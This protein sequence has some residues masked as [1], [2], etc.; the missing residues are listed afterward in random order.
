VNWVVYLFQFITTVVISRLLSPQQVGIFTLSMTIVLLLQ[1]LREFGVVSYIVQEKDLSDAKI[2]TVFATTI[3]V[4]WL[5]AS[6]LFASRSYVSHFYGEPTLEAILIIL[7]IS[8]V[9][10]PFGLPATAMLRRERQF[11]KLGIIS[12]SSSLVNLVTACSLA[13]YGFEARSLAY[14]TLASG[15]VQVAVSLFFWPKH[16][17]LKPSFSEWRDVLGFGLYASLASLIARIGQSSP[18]LLIGKIFG[19][20]DVAIFSRGRVLPLLLNRLVTSPV[21]NAVVPE[22]ANNLRIGKSTSSTL[23]DIISN[24]AFIYWSLLAFLFV[25]SELIIVAFYGNQWRESAALLRAICLSQG[26]L[27]LAAAPRMQLEAEGSVRK[28]LRNEIAIAII[29]VLTVSIGVNFG[30]PT[31]SWMMIC[32][33]VLAVVIYWSTIGDHILQAYRS[34]VVRLCLPMLA[35]I[36]IMVM[37]IAFDK[38]LG[39]NVDNH[40]IH[41]LLTVLLIKSAASLALFLTIAAVFNHPLFVILKAV[42]NELIKKWT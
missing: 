13:A 40:A 26:I 21:S 24:T 9:I 3:V 8:F 15:F 39:F 38:Y 6:L 12:F 7:C 4:G 32:P 20:H 16:V 33:S 14:A 41:Q 37:H 2:R 19:V 35:S 34:I 31:L 10:F 17:L 23:L 42:G 5:F 18:E 22:L 28:V 11:K 27:M 25:N 36:S 30:L 1:G 29:L